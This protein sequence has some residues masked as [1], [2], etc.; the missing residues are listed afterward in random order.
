MPDF[1][2]RGH[3]FKVEEQ[4]EMFQSAKPVELDGNKIAREVESPKPIDGIT[5]AT[6]NRSFTFKPIYTAHEDIKDGKGKIIV[7]KG[8]TVNPLDK[9]KPS[10]DLVFIEGTNKEHV[11]WATTLEA[12]CK[13]VLV[14]GNPLE[15]EKQHD[16]PVYFDQQGLYTKKLGIKRVPAIVSAQDNHLLIR[17]VCIEDCGNAQLAHDDEVS[18]E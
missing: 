18:N 5:E 8:T 13:W 11:K 10:S 15:L 6:Q 16:R 1:G 3:T 12:P 7:K 17:E 14:N 4:S 2:I 9:V